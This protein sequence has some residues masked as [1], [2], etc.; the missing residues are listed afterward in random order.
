MTLRLGSLLL[1]ILLTGAA[2][3]AMAQVRALILYNRPLQSFS[4]MYD[5]ANSTRDNATANST[6]LSSGR[7]RISPQY[8]FDM[9]HAILDPRL[10]TGHFGLTLTYN[11]E[12]VSG[13]DV[14]S[15]NTSNY[16]LGYDINGMFLKSNP[17]NA[18]YYAHR[19]QLWNQ[20]SF[21]AG[22]NSTV[23]SY[24]LGLNLGNK[25]LPTAVNYIWNR[26]VSQMSNNETTQTNG[27]VMLNTRH[28]YAGISSTNLNASYGQSNSSN[29]LPGSLEFSTNNTVLNLEN[30]LYFDISARP[31]QLTSTFRFDDTS[32][33]YQYRSYLLSENYD[34]RWGN[35]LN[36]GLSYSIQKAESG[37]YGSV[38]SQDS[39]S[40]VT[41]QLFSSLMTRLDLQYHS[42]SFE[43]V[44]E[45]TDKLTGTKSLTSSSGSESTMLSGASITYFKLLPQNS[46]L[47][48][49]ASTQYSITDR[50]MSRSQG[51][52]PAPQ[53]SMTLSATYM[54]NQLKYPNVDQTTVTL[55]NP[56]TKLPYRKCDT[57]VKNPD[58][59]DY[60]L[61][62]VSESGPTYIE[63]LPTSLILH[64]ND[65]VLINYDYKVDSTQKFSTLAFSTNSNLFLMDNRY[66]L[67]FNYLTSQQTLISGRADNFGLGSQTFLKAGGEYR[68]AAQMFGLA[69]AIS[70]FATSS[71]KMITETYTM[72]TP[73]LQGSILGTVTNNS[74]WTDTYSSGV[75][76]SVTSNTFSSILTY[77]RQLFRVGMLQVGLNYLMVRGDGSNRDGLNL[78]MNYRMALGR[79]S[80]N[81]SSQIALQKYSNS[82]QQDTYIKLILRRYF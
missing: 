50:D 37:H 12:F 17:Y 56:A 26:S 79:F 76:K 9:D 74:S 54:L 27:T 67:Y 39:R 19:E 71:Q 3:P 57:G 4:L 72:N 33:S 34:A 29:S 46:T 52:I 65:P 18:N 24:G 25:V 64:P 66:R 49:S 80:L 8:T 41:H 2:S 11:Q 75:Y 40:W 16:N 5:Y 1:I 61:Q 22:Y 44:S 38:T 10:Y 59:C 62:G 30:T 35:A 58:I 63:L 78:N 14:A 13:S 48:V 81:L 21:G 42:S 36:G 32:G 51:T 7:H 45:T 55:L 68:W 60:A 31:K 82:S 23:D 15:S 77:N 73:F 70:D 47:N 28:R 53:E 69:Y 6:G 20:S 43:G